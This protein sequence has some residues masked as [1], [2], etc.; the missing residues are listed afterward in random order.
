MNRPGPDL[1]PHWGFTNSAFF[2][3][4]IL[5]RVLALIMSPGLRGHWGDKRGRF[6]CCGGLSSVGLR[7][8]VQDLREQTERDFLKSFY[9]VNAIWPLLLLKNRVL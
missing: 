7:P 9:L 5:A 2:V 8:G 4:T 6:T 1:A 3:A